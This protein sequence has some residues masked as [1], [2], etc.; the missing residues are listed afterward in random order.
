MQ[1]K[2]PPQQ[3]Q[4]SLCLNKI[5]LLFHMLLTL[6]NNTTC[7]FQVIRLWLWAVHVLQ[8]VEDVPQLLAIEIHLTWVFQQISQGDGTGVGW[9]MLYPKNYVTIITVILKIC[10][11]IM[12]NGSTVITSVDTES[13]K[14]WKFKGTIQVHGL[15]NRFLQWDKNKHELS[16]VQL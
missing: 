16:I 7:R 6:M 3:H 14:I 8:G 5:H 4:H 2:V 12:V 13:F 10:W 1:Q 9:F 11:K 15:P